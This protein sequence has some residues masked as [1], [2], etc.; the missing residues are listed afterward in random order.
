VGRVY[1]YGFT[2]AEISSKMSMPLD[3][4]EPQIPLTTC[5]VLKYTILSKQCREKD[6]AE[7]FDATLRIFSTPLFRSLIPYDK[8]RQVFTD[9][10]F[11]MTFFTWTFLYDLRFLKADGSPR[12]KSDLPYRLFHVD[13]SSLFCAQLLDDMI[14]NSS[15]DGF[16][17]LTVGD[18]PLNQALITN[19]LQDLMKSS[20]N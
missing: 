18:V 15:T 12:M 4:L 20:F 7:V 9:G 5:Q 6:R 3:A 13:P 2:Q 19:P 11:H 17:G 1:L 8:L 14:N 16:N 10:L